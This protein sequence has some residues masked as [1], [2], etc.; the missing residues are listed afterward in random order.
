MR[1]W[2][3]L[4]M[5]YHQSKYIIKPCRAIPSSSL[6]AFDGCSAQPPTKAA[7]STRGAT[8]GTREKQ[9]LLDIERA[10]RCECRVRWHLR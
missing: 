4:L 3:G 8:A 10:D 5:L 1:A 6:L 2:R 9:D 7:R